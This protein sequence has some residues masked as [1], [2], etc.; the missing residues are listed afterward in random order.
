MKI[1]TRTVALAVALLP[2]CTAPLASAQ[3]EL[4]VSLG[5]GGYEGDL[6]PVEFSRRI[7]SLR[8]S[9][10]AYGRVPLAPRF[11]FAAHVQHYQVH[12]D[13]AFRKS[14]GGR[15]LSF[16]SKVLEFGAAAEY[17]P[18]GLNRSAAPFLS[19]GAALY[20][21]NP[22]TT[23]NGRVVELQPLGTEGQGLP[24]YAPR[25]GLTRLAIP[26]GGGVRIP[27]GSAWVV[28]A[29]ARVRMLLFDHLDDVSGNYV[30]YYELVQSNGSLAAALADRTGE[31]N[32]TEN[33]DIPSGTPRGDAA[34]DD[35][36]YT[37]SLTVGYRLGTGL[38]SGG[39][40]STGASRYNKCY[41]F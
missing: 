21:F 16:E 41:Q 31:L 22:T 8:P 38:F 28:G 39:G 12:G 34:D 3:T 1:L 23:F 6:G 20:R 32:G 15:N 36:T 14:S 26:L 25:Y 7:T 35:V 11:A 27:I 10:G 2:L 30:N 17:Y 4:G 13:D 24:G 9:F 5:A 19:A 40:R 33:R 29:Q 37:L 18:L